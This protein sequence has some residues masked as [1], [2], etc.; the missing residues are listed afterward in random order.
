MKPRK[1]PRRVALVALSL[2]AVPLA[3][4]QHILDSAQAN[5]Q[6]TVIQIRSLQNELDQPLDPSKHKNHEIELFN[7]LPL[8]KRLL[9]DFYRVEATIV[10]SYRVHVQSIWN[11]DRASYH[12]VDDTSFV[13]KL[14]D[15]KSKKTE[16]GMIWGHGKREGVAWPLWKHD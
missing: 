2:L 11:Y 15:S 4:A 10:R 3:R 5:Q 14:F 13:L 12:W 16:V 7:I 1:F 6:D 8:Q 9:V